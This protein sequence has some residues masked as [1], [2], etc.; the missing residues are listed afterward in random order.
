MQLGVIGL[1][2]GSGGIGGRL[3]Q[4]GR[5]CGVFDRIRKSVDQRVVGAFGARPVADL[6]AKVLWLAAAW[7][8]CRIVASDALLIAYRYGNAD[9]HECVILAATVKR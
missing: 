5:R 6:K 8:D 2:R 9:A 1:G 7:L 4:G 3:A